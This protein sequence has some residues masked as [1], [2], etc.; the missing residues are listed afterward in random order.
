MKKSVQSTQSQR[1]ETQ[2]KVSKKASECVPNLFTKI[3]GKLPKSDTTEFYSVVK[4]LL[5]Q[6]SVKAKADTADFLLFSQR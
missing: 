5:P 1:E 4:T 2:A 3:K 6:K